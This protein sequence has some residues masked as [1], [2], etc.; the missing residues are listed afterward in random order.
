MDDDEFL[1]LFHDGNLPGEEFRH[2]GHLRLA[3]LV[4]LRHGG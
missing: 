2:K 1:R 4:L 3:W